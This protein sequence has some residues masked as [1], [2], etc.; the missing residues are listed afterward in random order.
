MGYERPTTPFLDSLAAQGAILTNAITAGTPTYYSFPAILASRSPLALGR[1]VIGLSPGDQ[2]LATTLQDNGYRTGAFLAANP[3]LS[4]RFG[5][6]CGFDVFCDWL[7]PQSPQPQDVAEGR[8][9]GSFRS[10]ANSA[11]AHASHK[12]SPIGR[13]YDEM[14]FRYG[15]RAAAS[16]AGTLETLRR[17]PAADV[18]VDRACDWLSE[19]GDAP[20]FLWLHL[21]DPH[22]PYYPCEI[23]LKWMEKESLGAPEARHFNSCWNRSVRDA[24]RLSVHRD[25][26]VALY[27]AGIR[28][29]DFQISRL[30]TYLQKSQRWEN[31]AFAITADHGEE[32]L[33]HGGR[34]HAPE[35]LTEELIHVPLLL[36]APGLNAGLCL[37]APF[38]LVHLAPTLL[39]ALDVPAP[40][41]FRGRSYWPRI[42]K[43]QSWQEPAITECIRGCNNP[44]QT[45]SRIGQRMLSVRDE[46]FKLMIDFRDGSAKL[47]DLESDCAELAPLRQGFEPAVRKRLLQAAHR[48]LGTNLNSRSLEDRLSAKL[49]DLRSSWE[50]VAE[51]AHA[52]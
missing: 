2:T 38:S 42:R 24:S 45:E 3:Y 18:I 29:V 46:R 50:S 37:T 33:E 41:E 34:Y 17:F 21:M 44:F 43:N 31:C 22:A 30:V 6:H 15:Q 5:Y 35:K 40:S 25:N 36:R 49:Q 9:A 48:H 11:I 27:D 19:A 1:D 39:D 26:L 23:A 12:L 47:F 52:G 20:F 7:N 4:A 8:R 51:Q 28:W 13:L 32:F 10:R 14:Y 16:E